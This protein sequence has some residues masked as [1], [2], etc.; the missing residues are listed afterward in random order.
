VGNGNAK[1]RAFLA[2]FRITGSVVLSAEA[3]GVEKT[4][5]Y[6]W[7]KNEG[8]ARDFAEADKEFGDVLEACAI[9]RAKDGIL[10]AVFYQGEPCGAIRKYSDGLMVHLLKRFK[11]EKYATRVS[12][13]VN[14]SGSLDLVERLKA[15]RKRV[16]KIEPDD[17][18]RS[19]P[20]AG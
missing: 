16:N 11:P 13:D 10:E 1:A 15:A 6:R 14:V 19:E 8:Y 9:G 17:P 3:A 2:A 7:L 18:T 12:A 20:G 5:H 4:I